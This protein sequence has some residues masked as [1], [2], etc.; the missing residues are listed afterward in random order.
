MDE[1]GNAVPFVM[2]GEILVAG[3]YLACGYLNDPE[4]TQKK[5]IQLEGIRW[6]KTGDTGMFLLNGNLR[7]LGRKD[8]QL[9]IRGFR[10]EPFEV[11][12]LLHAVPGIDQAAVIAIRNPD[13]ALAA[14]YTGLQLEPAE[15]RSRCMAIMPDYMVPEASFFLK[16]LPRNINGKIDRNMLAGMLNEKAEKAA[17]H[18][19]TASIASECW[20]AVLGH[21]DFHNG[22]YFHQVGGNSVKLMQVQAWL[23]KHHGISVSVRELLLH[24]ELGQLNNLLSEKSSRTASHDLPR[25]FALNGVQKDLLRSELANYS[26]DCSP[27][28]LSFTCPVR[29]LPEVIPLENALQ[30][31]FSCYPHL[32]YGI[33]ISSDPEYSYWFFQ[34]S[35]Y[36][37]TDKPRN[38]TSLESG[39]PLLRIFRNGDKLEVQWHHILLDDVGIKMVMDHLYQTMAGKGIDKDIDYQSFLNV[40]ADNLVKPVTL[41]E[42]CKTEKFRINLQEKERLETTAAQWY[43]SLTSLFL[44]YL[45]KSFETEGPVAFTD[46]SQQPGIP[47]MF[48]ILN[49]ARYIPQL[50]RTDYTNLEEIIQ[51]GTEKNPAAGIVFNL[52][53]SPDVPDKTIS[54]ATSSPEFTKYPCEIQVM[55]DENGIDFTLYS[56]D[57][58]D[59]S[60][61]FTRFREL[62]SGPSAAGAIDHFSAG[63]DPA[64]N[65]LYDDFDF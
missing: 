14:F 12:N 18:P 55:I 19:Q 13:P 29:Y 8:E 54:L 22:D 61:K 17:I 30:N 56:G 64:E 38:S 15:F 40:R 44:L 59:Y 21:S 33:K 20:K 25:S 3:P 39:E 26:E 31:L 47:G 58:G 36:R 4:S 43:G 7:Y 60:A 42:K 34:D 50:H 63:N 45:H 10:V 57:S 62:L 48:T 53:Y 28:W 2:P 41:V 32:L 51:T 52:M 24:P 46:N 37:F 65:E 1:S 16:E 9:K 49:A 11:E 27:Y 6:Y 23:E 35:A 5:F